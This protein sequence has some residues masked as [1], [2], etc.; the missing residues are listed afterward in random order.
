MINQPLV[1]VL[2]VKCTAN[3]EFYWKLYPKKA[4]NT[5]RFFSDEKQKFA[6][7]IPS[8]NSRLK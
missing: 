6:I 2:P 8:Q 5:V 3:Q 1:K 7:M 4:E